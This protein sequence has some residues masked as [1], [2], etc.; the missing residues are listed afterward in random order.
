M[1]ASSVLA[2]LAAALTASTIV[3]TPKES[4]GAARGRDAVHR[5]GTITNDDYP[6]S[7]LRER[8]EGIS[9]IDLEIGEDGRVTGCKIAGSSGNS[10]L[11]STAC[12]L[13]RRRFRFVPATDAKGRNVPGRSSR[14]VYWRLPDE[15]PGS[16]GTTPASD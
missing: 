10:A 6:P 7:A 4:A 11:D 3:G 9:E 15:I 14:S 13:A 8:A 5:S 16:S 2:S 12:S 1:I